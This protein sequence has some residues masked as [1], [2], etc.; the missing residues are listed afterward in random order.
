MAAAAV[1]AQGTCAQLGGTPGRLQ[2]SALL[3]CQECEGGAV[4]CVVTGSHT[5]THARTVRTHCP[6]SGGAWLWVDVCWMGAAH[7]HRRCSHPGTHKGARGTHTARANQPP[8]PQLTHT[9]GRA[10]FSASKTN[11]KN[12]QKKTS[13]KM[14]CFCIPKRYLNLCISDHSMTRLKS[15]LFFLLSPPISEPLRGPASVGIAFGH[16]P[17]T[18]YSAVR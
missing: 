16:L 13:V 9:R 1:P 11:P 12:N 4:R 2:R 5:A 7:D 14:Y 10:F 3:C 17:T 18:P 6:P 8:W 15:N